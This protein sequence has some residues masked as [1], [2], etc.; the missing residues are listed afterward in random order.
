MRQFCVSGSC[1]ACGECTLQTD[2]LLEDA[3]G[4]V[5]PAADCYIK[6]SEL[7][8]AKELVDACPAHALS[9]VEKEDV[10]ID[11]NE[12]IISLKQKLESVEIPEYPDCDLTFEPKKY[13]I[14]YSNATGEY[15]YVY[16]SEHK[17]LNEGR[18]RFSK[19]FW[20]RRK[21][22]ALSYLAQYKTD[23]LSQFYNFSDLDRTWYS[24]FS[25][26][27]ETILKEAKANLCA[28]T[29]NDNIFPEDFTTFCPE[30]DRS[31]QNI[32]KS[33]IADISSTWY[34]NEFFEGFDKEELF[35]KSHYEHYIETKSIDLY[36][37]KNWLGDK[38]KSYYAFYNVNE[39]GRDLVEDIGHALSC[40]PSYSG[41]KAIDTIAEEDLPYLIRNYQKIVEEE[42][43][44]KLVVYSDVVKKNVHKQ[45][46][47]KN[48]TADSTGRFSVSS[49]AVDDI[50]D[51]CSVGDNNYD[52]ILETYKFVLFKNRNTYERYKEDQ[53]KDKE[54]EGILWCPLVIYN[55]QTE[56]IRG[57]RSSYHPHSSDC[58]LPNGNI[59][60]CDRTESDED[61][62]NAIF[63]FDPETC[64]SRRISE[65]F[66]DVDDFDACGNHFVYNT[67]ED[68][69]VFVV[70]L[71]TK[72][73]K[74][75]TSD[76]ISDCPYFL[77]SSDG[78][79][80]CSTDN[81]RTISFYDCKT[82][83]VSKMWEL[84][85]DLTRLL[86]FESGKLYVS[87]DKKILVIDINKKKICKSIDNVSWCVH[88]FTDCLVYVTE[89][90]D[91]ETLRYSDDNTCKLV[92]AGPQRHE[93]LGRCGDWILFF[94]DG[95]KTKPRKVS[96]QNPQ[97]VEHLGGFH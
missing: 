79:L 37:G 10:K 15:D 54:Y 74:W 29:G 57:V 55:K 97:Q 53:A 63:E 12:L 14:D 7:P 94:E 22:F 6:N 13:Q 87:T 11:E 46:A 17:A 82:E 36:D 5:Y 26:C 2:L 8:L 68:D 23:V 70:N 40:A 19:L 78:V 34:V 95:D 81:E 45:K 25:K 48:N 39:E 69:G 52:S 86:H 21:E 49:E 4:H 30:L 33:K 88:A 72:E 93:F 96:L 66:V 65:F 38:F 20:D 77:A 76:E 42:I 44:K 90:G 80:L 31:F 84:D 71:D 35:K 43:Q 64:E 9:I 1:T 50:Y 61:Y 59:L 58:V 27:I 41:L 3:T 83:K 18:S 60:Y 62:A 92:S 51:A 67:R 73:K 56:Q 47:P 85:S 75:L 32:C 16:S 91:I 28:A 89:S 24:Q